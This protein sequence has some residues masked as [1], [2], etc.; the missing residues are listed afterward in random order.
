MVRKLPQEKTFYEFDHYSLDVTQQVLLRNG[1]LVPLPP[2]A[3]DLLLALVEAGGAVVGKEELLGRV[4]PDTFVE[5]GSLTQNISTL[6]RTLGEKGEGLQYIQTVPRRGYRFAAPVKPAKAAPEPQLPRPVVD[7]DHQAAHDPG[8]APRQTKLLRW[9]LLGAAALVLLGIG[10]AVSM[11]TGKKPSTGSIRSLAVLP[12]E[13]LSHDPEQEYFADGITDALITNLAKIN[14]LHVVSRTSIVGYKG[15]KMPI[16]QIARD[17]NVDAIVEGTVVQ[18]HGRVRITAQLVSARSATHLW[19]EQYEGS[20]AEI[21][22]IQDSVARSVAHE[23]QVKVTPGEQALLATPR[24]V[25]PGAYEAYLRGRYWLDRKGG[26]GNLRRSRDYLEQAIEKDP[27][28]APAWAG[29]ADAYVDLAS[30]G[31]IPY[32]DSLP[33]ARAAAE[34]ALELDGSL[35]GPLVTLANVKLGYEWDWHGAEELCKRVIELNPNYGEAHHAYATY[36]AEVG[37]TREA[38]AEARRAREVE[39]LSPVF[40]ANV[41]WKLYLARNFDDAESEAHRVSIL[42]PGFSLGYVRASLYLQTARQQEAVAELKKT[43]VEWG[44]GAL[45][46]MYLAHGLGVAG[47]Q[48]EGQQ[49]LDEM[50]DRSRRG[51]VPPD[52]IAVAYEGLGQREQALRWYEKAFAERSINGWILPDPQLDSLRAE[53]RFQELLRKMGLNRQTSSDQLSQ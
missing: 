33:R 28:Y 17:L 50:L 11:A 27:G 31:E 29:L 24:A 51:Y 34:K 2:K 32:R 14:S 45:D 6:R 42:Y 1:E 12:L 38:V 13:N 8:P 15:T 44:R 53:S 48:A 22:A 16:Q 52:Y 10:L 23:I 7:L 20:M 39:P 4:W 40:Q 19:A 41:V 30:W 35:V 47:A 3:F 49:V 9:G 18:D 26:E 43:V 25:D 5:E 21:L 46:L 37:R 36:L